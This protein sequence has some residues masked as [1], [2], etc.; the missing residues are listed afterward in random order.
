MR[1]AEQHGALLAPG[2]TQMQLEVWTYDQDL[3]HTCDLFARWE[4]LTE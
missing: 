3:A 4:R 1:R 2:D